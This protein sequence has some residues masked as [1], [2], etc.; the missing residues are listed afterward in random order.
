MGCPP[1]PAWG[2]HWKAI[3]TGFCGRQTTL[4]LAAARTLMRPIFL[5]GQPVKLSLLL[6]IP[7]PFPI[8]EAD[9]ERT[10]NKD[11]FVSSSGEGSRGERAIRN[12]WSS[13]PNSI[14]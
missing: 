10:E 5:V 8:G 1:P 4:A 14:L 11:P 7:D 2:S 6:V 9:F 3:H 12:M 13:N